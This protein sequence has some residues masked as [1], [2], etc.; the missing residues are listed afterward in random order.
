MDIVNI[1]LNF[2]CENRQVKWLSVILFISMDI[3]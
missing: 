1:E 2:E 3:N